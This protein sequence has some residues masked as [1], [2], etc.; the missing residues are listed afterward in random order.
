MNENN[1]TR[2]AEFSGVLII[3]PAFNE[4]A[5]IGAVLDEIATDMP[6]AD[7]L[8]VD[9]CSTDGTLDV[10]RKYRKNGVR[11]IS[12]VFNMGYAIAIQTGYKYAYRHGYEYVLQMDADG[13]H[14]AKEARKLYE[15]QRAGDADIIIGSRYMVDMGY[16]A[17]LARRIGTKMFEW[18]I[19]VSCG[20]RICDPLS[21]FQCLNRKVISRY[22]K[23]GGVPEF[24]D[25]N[26]ILE[27]IRN[28]FTVKEVPVR[29]RLREAGESM[30]GGI[31]KPIKYMFGMMYEIFFIALSSSKQSERK[32]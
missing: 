27:M 2:H 29:M 7:V 4:A 23:L 17:P 18:A 28:G 26:L 16:P 31:L 1:D 6:E 5:S 14:I 12:H 10:V 15:A 11:Y 22:S 3:I 30:H 9:D 13:Q 24:P 21:G 32:S 8:V 25:A 20:K 19:K